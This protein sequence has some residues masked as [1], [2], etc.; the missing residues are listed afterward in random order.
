VKDHASHAVER[1][2]RALAYIRAGKMVILTDDEDRENEGDLCMAAEKVTPAAVNFMAKHGRGLVCLSLTEEKVRQLRLPL[3]VDEASNSSSFGTAFTI[4]IEA[5]EGVTT[6]ISAKDRAHTI[7]TAVRDGAKAEDLARPGHV[8]PLRARKGGVLVRAGQT[9]GSVDLARLAGLSPAGVICE[10]M[11]DD[12]S[13]A[14]MPELEALARE[15][16][17]PLVSVADLISYRMMK[18]TLV[19]RGAEAPLPTGYGEFR[20]VAYENDVDQHHHVA[21]VKGR[22]RHDE[23]VLVRVHSKCLTGDVFG[24]ERCDCGPQL[25]AALEQIERAGKGVLLYLDQEGRGIGLVNKLRAYN[26]QDEGYDTAEA[27]LRLGFKPDLRDYGIGAQILRD[28]GVRK[29]KLLTNN[30]KKIVGLEGYGLEV[31]ERV[32]IEMAPTRR[33]RAYLATKR[34]KMGHL[35]TLAPAAP[36]RAAARRPAAKGGKPVKAARATRTRKGRDGR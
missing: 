33:N 22:W 2:E 24:S 3:M 30:P 13:M 15:H 9:E 4:S 6:G 23:A 17:L 27:N 5:R 25:H 29:M 20:A 18:D 10:V 19:R 8:F 34:D 1:V 16:D 32:P 21:L 7:L 11:K 14:R 12:G 36:A 35:L 28:L 31:L 26:L